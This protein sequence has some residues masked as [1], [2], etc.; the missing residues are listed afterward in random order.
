VLKKQ[1]HQKNQR[2]TKGRRCKKKPHQ[3]KARKKSKK[4][5]KEIRIACIL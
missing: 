1:L 3:E 2:R 4:E 5:R